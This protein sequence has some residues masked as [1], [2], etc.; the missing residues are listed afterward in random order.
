M[1]TAENKQEPEAP[2]KSKLDI[3]K[4]YSHRIANFLIGA[5]GS[6]AFLFIIIAFF[7]FWIDWNLNL[8]TNFKP[9]DPFPF[10]ILTMAVSMFAIILSITVLISQNRQNR[11]EK[12][13]QQVE[14]EVNVRAENE[15]TKVL[16]M[17]H[18]IQKK[19]GMEEGPDKE[20]E[21]M[22]EKLDIKELH[23]KLDDMESES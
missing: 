13:R 5:F 1:A 6:M 17:L 11:I 10:P 14:F 7:V 18:D 2:V 23:Q 20:L 12:I 4:S 15:I 8:I 21:E 22:K 9:F 19:L 16:T 3:P